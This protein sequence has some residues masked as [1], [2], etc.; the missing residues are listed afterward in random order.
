M[1][2]GNHSPCH[3]LGTLVEAARVLRARKDIVFAFIGG[4]SE[5]RKIR[6]LVESEKWGNVKCLPYQPRES[7]AQSLSAGDL[8]AVVMGDPFVGIVSPSK[9]YNILAVGAPVLYIGPTHSHV[10]ELFGAMDHKPNFYAVEHSNVSKLVGHILR[11]KEQTHSRSGVRYDAEICK[12]VLL[13]QMQMIVTGEP[14]REAKA[15]QASLEG[16]RQV[17]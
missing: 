12:D 3:P 9:I 11:A 6:A 7:L 14:L 17:S 8:H 10:T 16:I 4:G 1:Y 5:Y 13:P 15:D 2:S